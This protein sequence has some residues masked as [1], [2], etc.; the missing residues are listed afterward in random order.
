MLDV[1]FWRFL[2][3]F[4]T[5]FDYIE[6]RFSQSFRQWFCSKMPVQHAI[7]KHLGGVFRG[8]QR[9]ERIILAHIFKFFGAFWDFLGDVGSQRIILYKLMHSYYILNPRF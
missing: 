3:G 6:I 7:F 9:P 8:V 1:K 4:C 5:Y 2:G